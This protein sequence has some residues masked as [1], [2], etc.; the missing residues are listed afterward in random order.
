MQEL[1]IFHLKIWKMRRKINGAL[2][3]K[4]FEIHGNVRYQSIPSTAWQC[5]VS[6]G[7]EWSCES[8]PKVELLLEVSV[9]LNTK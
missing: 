7:V 4:T 8:S 5:A 1:W 2:L 9:S 6:S 3:H